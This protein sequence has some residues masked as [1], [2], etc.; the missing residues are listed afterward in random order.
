MEGGGWWRAP[1]TVSR[2]IS[3]QAAR[4]SGR[5]PAVTIVSHSVRCR[6]CDDYWIPVFLWVTTPWMDSCHRDAV[7]YV[8]SHIPWVVAHGCIP[9]TA[10]QFDMVF[11]LTVGYA[12]LT[13]GC[14]PITASRFVILAFCFQ[15]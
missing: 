12:S 14:I 4:R 6:F 13:H 10:T 9:V 11:W 2:G 7:L 15:L 1:R 5:L 8:F 3:P